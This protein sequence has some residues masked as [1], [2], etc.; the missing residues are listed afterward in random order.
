VMRASS[1]TGLQA[2]A[3]EGIGVAALPCFMGDSDP[4]LAR[5]LAPVPEMASSLWLL[6][7]PDLRRTARVRVVLDALAGHVMRLRRLLEGNA[8]EAVSPRGD[9]AG[10][11]PPP[12]S[13]H[14][15]RTACGSS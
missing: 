3:R 6:T 15:R 5:V 9:G 12:R 2:A 10:S 11:R 4:R 7:Q 13:G 1:L 14:P 8:S